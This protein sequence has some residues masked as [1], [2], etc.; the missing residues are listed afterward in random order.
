MESIVSPFS[1]EQLQIEQTQHFIGRLF[2]G[3][4]DQTPQFLE[5]L[6][7]MLQ[8][9]SID[10]KAAYSLSVYFDDPATGAPEKLASFHAVQPLDQQF[11]HEDFGVFDF[12]PGAYIRY[13]TTEPALIW[14]AFGAVHT[15][16]GEKGI[17]LAT[18][19]PF[20]ISSF[21]G[22]QVQFSFYF[23]VS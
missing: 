13:T 17:V 2:Y 19:P 4:Y 10:C 3:P 22:G 12:E 23:P 8:A 16:T 6:Q 11:Y 21:D 18:P 20:L 15:Y 1:I 9:E 14:H 7:G 5:Q